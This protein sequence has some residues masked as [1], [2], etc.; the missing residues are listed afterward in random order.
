MG[1]FFKNFTILYKV[2]NF[3]DYLCDFLLTKKK[4]PSK[5]GFTRK[6][7]NSLLRGQIVFLDKPL[8]RRGKINFDRVASPESVSVPFT[9]TAI[10]NTEY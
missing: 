2:E 3:C 7:K 10:S 4:I 8:F 1:F 9:N 6:G 5:K